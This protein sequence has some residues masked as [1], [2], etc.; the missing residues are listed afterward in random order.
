MKSWNL[1][2]CLQKEMDKE[3]IKK[4]IKDTLEFT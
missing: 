1:N 3:E 2:I 4:Q